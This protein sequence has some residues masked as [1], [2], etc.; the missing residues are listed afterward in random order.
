MG[1]KYAHPDVLDGGPLVI[2]NNATKVV[3]VKN[4]TSTDSYATVTGN[5]IAT[6]TI[7]AT[8]FTL[9]NGANGARALTF[10]GKSATAAAAGKAVGNGEDHEFAFLDGTSRI[11]WVTDE[12]A[13]LANA[14]GDTITFP[15]LIYTSNQPA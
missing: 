13:E 8:D 14:I 1:T 9:G 6:A 11:L 15:S 4:F 5:A 12:T 2:K 10:N 7:S 3:L